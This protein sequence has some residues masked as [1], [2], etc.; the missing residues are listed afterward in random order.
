VQFNSARVQDELS[1]F[2]KGGIAGEEFLED[3]METLLGFHVGFWDYVTFIA[4]FIVVVTFLVAGV[5]ILG[6]P[7]R[8]AIARNHPEA[9]AV[10]LMGWIGFL[11]IVPWIQALIWAFKPTNVID[12]RYLPEEERRETDAMI[13]RL[14]GAVPS[15]APPP[16]RSPTS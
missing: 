4:I 5:F 6:L 12:I 7:G 10:N 1:Q 16:D 9:D 11:A 2:A 14:R 15:P 13:A 3:N 8:I